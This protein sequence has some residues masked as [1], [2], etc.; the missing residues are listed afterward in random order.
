MRSGYVTANAGYGIRSVYTNG[1][2]ELGTGI[3]IGPMNAAVGYS[4]MGREHWS[5]YWRTQHHEDATDAYENA[6]DS[7]EQDSYGQAT[8][9]LWIIN[10]DGSELRPINAGELTDSR[11]L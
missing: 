5:R 7:G 2:Y 11:Q 10:S 9:Y 6:L 1:Q 8:K 4:S 3:R